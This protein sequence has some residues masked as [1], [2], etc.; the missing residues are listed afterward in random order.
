MLA[1]SQGRTMLQRSTVMA[2]SK[3]RRPNHQAAKP[4]P[5]FP[6]TA[7]PTRRWC[8]KVRGKIHFFGKIIPNDGGDSAQAALD[9]W[10]DEKDALLAGRTPRAE[11]TGLT[12][13]E[14]ADRFMIYK[15]H[16]VDAG[17]L[18][19]STWNEYYST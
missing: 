4:H 8:K 10:L 2:H 3:R 13:R 6:L 9:K 14:M 12:I 19:Q 7:H 17:E 18:K 11:P 16:L 5:D 1:T 15:Q